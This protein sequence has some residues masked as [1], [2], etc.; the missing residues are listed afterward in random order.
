MGTL[1]A[2]VKTCQGNQ[3]AELTPRNA[4]MKKNSTK[5]ITGYSYHKGSKREPVKS[6]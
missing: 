5:I 1:F 2:C 6:R 4:L 3:A